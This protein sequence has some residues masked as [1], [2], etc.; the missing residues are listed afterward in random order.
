MTAPL[1]EAADTWFE[2]AAPVVREHQLSRF[3]NLVM[4]VKAEPL[5]VQLQYGAAALDEKLKRFATALRES[6]LPGAQEWLKV[7][8]EHRGPTLSEPRRVR[9]QMALRLLGWLSQA[10]D[11]YPSSLSLLAGRYRT[12]VAWVDWARTV[13]LEGDD[14]TELATAF[15]QLP[16]APPGAAV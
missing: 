4:Q 11:D 6:D 8:T 9:C 2:R 14:S 16:T 3:E 13:L 12:E 5:A 10:G 15:A 7:V 1:A